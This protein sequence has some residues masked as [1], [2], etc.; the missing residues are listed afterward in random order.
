VL[1]P[2]DAQRGHGQST[3]ARRLWRAIHIE[4]EEM[5]SLSVEHPTW[6]FLFSQRA[7]QHIFQK[8]CAQGLDGALIKRG[9]KARERRA[10]GLAISSEECHER[11]CPG[12]EA[13]VKGFQRPF[14]AYGIALRARRE[15]RS[16]RPVRS[17]D[18]L[19]A[20]VLR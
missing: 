6:L 10:R 4:N 12:L 7:S 13:L 18:G 1:N 5:V 8:Q 20:P 16:P 2:R 9:E 19:S 3:L 14:A 17:G 11:V 15:N